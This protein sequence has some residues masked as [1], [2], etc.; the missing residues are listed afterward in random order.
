MSETMAEQA[1]GPGEPPLFGGGPPAASNKPAWLV[2]PPPQLDKGRWPGGAFSPSW[3]KL[4]HLCP[5]KHA[6]NYRRRMKEPASPEM[7]VGTAVHS[8]LAWA[9]LR[10]LRATHRGL[11]G[12][13][14]TDELLH[15]VEHEPVARTDPA[16]LLRAREI[17]T[18]MGPISFDGLI[19]V[20]QLVTWRVGS[21]N[22]AGYAD[23]ISATGDPRNPDEVVI[24]DYKTGG[25]VPDEGELFYDPQA[26][27]YAV[28][29]RAAYPNARR[30]VFRIFNVTSMEE[31][32]LAWTRHME[33]GFLAV[34]RA[35]TNAWN[36][37]DETPKP[38]SHCD[39]CHVR[40]RCKAFHDRLAKAKREQ[41]EPDYLQRLTLE[42]KIE[43]YREMHAVHAMSE[44]AKKDLGAMIDS[45]IPASL[46]SY[47]AGHL[48]ATRKRES[49]TS[50][51]GEAEAVFELS[52]VTG[53]PFRQLAEEL[54]KGIGAGKLASF[55]KGLP[56]NMRPLAEDVIRRRCSK[57]VSGYHIEVRELKGKVVF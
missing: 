28:S 15:L 55:L 8:A 11:P 2:D 19:A 54:M 1:E 41:L 56:D 49:F 48:Q 17:I 23:Q 25:A 12:S 5:L 21:V 22:L 16:V 14:S 24:T 29:A 51:N 13:A 4:M 32:F 39:Y 45:D 20:E 26:C 6:E 18:G 44:R 50:W 7:N 42:Q 57:G 47:T 43:K 46:K 38:G 37:K 10:R 30:I 36:A 27:M 52:E 33:E 40:T 53:V 9:G 35:A 3:L 31:R 34:V